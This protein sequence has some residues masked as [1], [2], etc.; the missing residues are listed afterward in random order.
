MLGTQEL[1]RHCR[2][3]STWL[4]PKNPVFL[5]TTFKPEIIVAAAVG[6][7]FMIVGRVIYAGHYN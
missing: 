7:E 1:T 5:N 6:R 2:L 4:T 3:S